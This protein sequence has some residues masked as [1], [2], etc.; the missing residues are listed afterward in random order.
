MLAIVKFVAFLLVLAVVASFAVKNGQEVTLH[1]YFGLDSVP[2]PLFLILFGSMVLGA[3]LSLLFAVGEQLRLRFSIRSMERK[4]RRME[5]E[6]HSLRNLPLTSEFLE[7][8]EGAAEGRN[9]R[10]LKE[11]SPDVPTR[12]QP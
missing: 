9:R 2:L 11:S 6:L 5:D 12:L 1:Y 4:M 10:S 3:L 7:Q 8:E